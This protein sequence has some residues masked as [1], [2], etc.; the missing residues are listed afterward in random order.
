MSLVEVI[1]LMMA[2]WRITSLIGFE[3]GPFDI[4]LKFRNKIGVAE[5]GENFTSKLFICIW[6][7][8]V[9]VAPVA[10]LVYLSLPLWVLLIPAVSTGVIL[11]DKVISE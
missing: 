6:C 10:V 11:L 8:S 1:V 9:W 2:A 7:L 5:E 3:E 4:I